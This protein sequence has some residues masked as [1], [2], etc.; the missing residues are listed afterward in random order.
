MRDLILFDF[1]GTLDADGE[2]WSIRFHRAYR[3]VGGRA[4][5][6]E[7]EPAFRR[8]DKMLGAIPQIF[9]VGFDVMVE[10]QAEIL[11][12]LIPDARTLPMQRA[13]RLFAA[14]TKETVAR[15]RGILVGFKERYRLGIV[16]NFTG[17]LSVCLD[18]LELSAL[19]DV[20]ADSGA[21]GIEKPDPA[22]FRWVTA[23]VPPGSAPVWM[24]GDN[25]DADI[26][27][28]ASLGFN[29]CWLAPA[30]RVEPSPGLATKRA[31]SLPDVLAF[32]A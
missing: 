2:R 5:F 20:V 13:A 3:Q 22:I 32:F 7:F 18:E 10:A 1:G 9:G 11:A 12:G 19:F 6:A 27:P 29:T 4:S 24:I 26:R 16:A 8:S 17:N 31:A 30:R 15:N 25:F 14:E 21:I 28:A 23:R